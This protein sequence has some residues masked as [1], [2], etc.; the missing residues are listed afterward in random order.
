[1]TIKKIQDMFYLFK[2]NKV[3]LASNSLASLLIRYS[4]IRG[5]K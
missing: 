4:Q 5:A 2:D 3:I 1:M